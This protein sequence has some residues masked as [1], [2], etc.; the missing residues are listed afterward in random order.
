MA[1]GA[2][3]FRVGVDF[4]PGPTNRCLA[5]GKPFVSDLVYGIAYDATP[6]KAEDD[7]SREYGYF[8]WHESCDEGSLAA[9]IA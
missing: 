2:T 1:D 8:M 5:C 6:W 4:H 7:E 3:R 9:D